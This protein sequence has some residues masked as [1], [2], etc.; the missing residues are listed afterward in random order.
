M[1]IDLKTIASQLYPI[2]FLRRFVDKLYI[3]GAI[4]LGDVIFFPYIIHPAHPELSPCIQ[5]K[6]C[7]KGKRY[8]TISYHGK[9]KSGHRLS[10]DIF[11]CDLE[12]DLQVHHWCNNPSCINPAHLKM[13]TPAENSAYMVLMGRQARGEKNGMA[14]LTEEQV[15]AIFIAYHTQVAT[16][17]ELA[18]M[19]DVSPSTVRDIMN[20]RYWKHTLRENGLI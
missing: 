12:D 6:T 19:Y 1:I 3:P 17:N 7:I 15:I 4:I 8:P 14:V 18:A 13:G 5:F 2:E 9:T 20:G 16:I 11:H 10:Y